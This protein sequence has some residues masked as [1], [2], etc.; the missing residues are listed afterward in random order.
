[1]PNDARPVSRLVEGVRP[2]FPNP[3]EG[4]IDSAEPER[5]I[6]SWPAIVTGVEPGVVTSELFPLCR[7]P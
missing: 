6:D 2:P 4:E 1:M 7:L 5:G 3:V